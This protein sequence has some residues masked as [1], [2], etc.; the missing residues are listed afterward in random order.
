MADKA[1]HALSAAS[2]FRLIASYLAPHIPTPACL[3]MVSECSRHF[4]HSEPSH[5]LIPNTYPFAFC[6]TFY[7]R[8]IKGAFPK[9]FNPKSP[10]YTHDT[11]FFSFMAV[12]VVFDNKV[13]Y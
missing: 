13:I 4:P 5:M 6:S 11:H 9:L 2:L 3:P 8:F 7:L 12:I 10:S 1:P